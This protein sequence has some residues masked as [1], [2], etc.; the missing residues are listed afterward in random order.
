[1]SCSAQITL[2]GD[3]YAGGGPITNLGSPVSP[4]DAVT[5]RY[6]DMLTAVPAV[7]SY[8]Y[9]ARA[10]AARRPWSQS[11]ATRPASTSLRRRAR[12]PTP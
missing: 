9:A 7:R 5:K 4:A 1:M 8:R 12:S 11:A 10:S 6:I 3:L 2:T